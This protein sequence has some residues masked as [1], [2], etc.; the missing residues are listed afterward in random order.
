M[1]DEQRNGGRGDVK[2]ARPASF[3]LAEPFRALLRKLGDH[4]GLSDV[5]VGEMI[6]RRGMRGELGEPSAEWQRYHDRAGLTEVWVRRFSEEAVRAL[7]EVARRSALSEADALEWLVWS[8]ARRE[9][10]V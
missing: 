10:L 6:S 2:R 1:G 9:G 3:R 5:S 7:Q 8:A 4:W